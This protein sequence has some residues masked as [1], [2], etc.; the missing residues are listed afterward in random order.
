MRHAQALNLQL[1]HGQEAV[2]GIAVGRA[3]AEVD[4]LGAGVLRLAGGIAPFDRHAVADEAVELPVVLE[5]RPGE[6][7]PRQLLDGLLAGDFR[8]AGVEALQGAARRSRTSI[9][10]RSL[11]RPSVPVGPKVSSL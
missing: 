9:T 10:S 5:Q 1:A 2:V 11:A 3:V 8:Q 7:H 6:V 4:D